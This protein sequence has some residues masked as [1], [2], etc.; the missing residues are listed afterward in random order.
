MSSPRTTRDGAVA[1]AQQT[2]KTLALGRL[3]GGA[4]HDFNNLLTATLGCPE[5]ALAAAA[6][7]SRL[8]SHVSQVLVAGERASV[9]TRRLRVLQPNRRVLFASAGPDADGDRAAHSEGGARVLQKPFGLD[10][11]ASA[12]REV[13]DELKPSGSSAHGAGGAA[14]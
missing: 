13:L 3:A 5:M 12:V 4:A 8:A 1:D 2:E 7:S 9:L 10:R 11:L 14:D 6:P